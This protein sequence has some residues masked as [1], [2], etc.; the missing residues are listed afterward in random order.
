MKK[1]L[2]AAAAGLTIISQPIFAGGEEIPFSSNGIYLGIG[3]S[4]NFAQ[5][6]ETIL[7]PGGSTGFVTFKNVFGLSPIAQLGYDHYSPSGY[8]F[9][10]KGLFI[11]IDKAEGVEGAAFSNGAG[12]NSMIA[13]MLVGGYRYGDNVSYLEAGYSLLMTSETLRDTNAGSTAIA[14]QHGNYSGGIIGIRSEE[15]TS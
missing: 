2:L 4:Y 6:E 10:I 15:H 11:Y 7:D 8:L 9:G 5:Y 1:L 12:F 14:I 3:G 13:A